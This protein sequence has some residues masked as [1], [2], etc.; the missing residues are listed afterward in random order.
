[1]GPLQNFHFATV[2]LVLGAFVFHPRGLAAPQVAS[3]LVAVQNAL[4]LQIQAPVAVRQTLGDILVYGAL[5][6]AEVSGCGADR[7]A[8]SMIRAARSQALSSI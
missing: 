1:M 3:R 2:L 8:F 6:D 5:R 7:G 4:H